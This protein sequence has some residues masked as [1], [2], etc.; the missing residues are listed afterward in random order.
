MQPGPVRRV[1]LGAALISTA[2]LP[3]ALAASPAFADPVEPIEI[4]LV[5]FNDFHESVPPP[6]SPPAVPEDPSAVRFAG[7]IEAI[8]AEYG[9][10]STLLLSAGDILRE[11]GDQNPA[12][13]SYVPT[14][15]VL[16]ALDLAA[17]TV[18]NHEFHYGAL[19]TNGYTTP[20][21]TT[22]ATIADFPFL[23]ANI[24]KSSIAQFPAY[25]TFNVA[26]VKVAVI[27]ATTRDTPYLDPR[28]LLWGLTFTDPVAAVNTTAANLK[29]SPNPPDVIV[30]VYHEAATPTTGGV[31]GDRIHVYNDTSA[32]VDAIFAGHVHG[33]SYADENGP[34]PGEPVKKRPVVQS[35]PYGA[36]VSKVVLSIDPDTKEILSFDATNVNRITDKTREELIAAYPRAKD[37]DDI[38]HTARPMSNCPQ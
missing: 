23:S 14:L 25:D 33:L 16:N 8:R 15:C 22:I 31:T 28:H 10:E 2:S 29:A 9:E 1:L 3:A 12:S 35:A 37:V 4:A 30:A 32:D 19:T 38:V 36:Q 34:I 6:P 21:K 20:L 27:G 24:F 18:G 11:G 7:T 26:G 17:N 13:K 5:G